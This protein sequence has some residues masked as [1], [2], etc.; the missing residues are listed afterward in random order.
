MNDA[1]IMGQ[2]G[3]AGWFV[4]SDIVAAKMMQ[5]AIANKGEDGP[6]VKV[7]RTEAQD[8]MKEARSERHEAKSERVGE[9]REA[10]SEKLGEMREMRASEKTEKTEAVQQVD[11][12]E[13]IAATRFDASL[14][15][16][17]DRNESIALLREKVAEMSR[18]LESLNK[19]MDAI[20][21]FKFLMAEGDSASVVAFAGQVLADMR[22]EAAV[23]AADPQDVTA[24]E[25]DT[26]D[27]AET[28]E[29]E[30]DITQTETSNDDDVI[31]LTGT[32]VSQV[33]GGAGND[34]I[35]IT[36]D[37]IS[38]IYGGEG[39]DQMVFNGQSASDMDGGMG[40][41]VMDITAVNVGPM[42]DG[43]GND[44]V[45][46][47]AR[48]V[49]M[50]EF[51]EG[52]DVF[53]LNVGGANVRLQAGVGEDVINLRDA[54]ILEIFVRD[55]E[56]MMNDAATEW[57]GDDLF[58]EFGTGDSVLINNAANAGMLTI[59]SENGVINLTPQ[60]QL[61]DAS[62]MLDVML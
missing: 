3:N 8:A 56:E 40:D 6:N 47:T 50:I 44:V 45:T 32:T 1:L 28:V 51:D 52:N 30:G 57:R 23:N 7:L 10:R 36:A 46:V 39:N 17:E 18:A 38:R 58:V 26:V 29:V 48:N 4:R 27:D 53:N 13:S 42:S 55:S 5:Q 61:T 12:P 60:V 14:A 21:E 41:D 33:Y 11:G 35:T 25:V 43:K 62:N 31:D 54:A 34:K 49:E 16:G 37:T 19:A 59:R 22:A 24:D 15:F 9:F 20:G 2:R